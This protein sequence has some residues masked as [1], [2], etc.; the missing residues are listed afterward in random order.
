MAKFNY[1][2]S[3][4]AVTES[5]ADS[6]MKSLTILAQRLSAKELE[7]LA[8]IVKNDPVKLAMAKSALG[9]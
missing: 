8:Y 7:K 1:D 4:Q 2:F 3:I 6:K 9:V 5:E